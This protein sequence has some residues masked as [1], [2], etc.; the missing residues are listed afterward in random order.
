M[1]L[2]LKRSFKGNHIWVPPIPQQIKNAEQTGMSAEQIKKQCII[3]EK[4][5]HRH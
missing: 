1:G 4:D 2:V 3:Y 5:E